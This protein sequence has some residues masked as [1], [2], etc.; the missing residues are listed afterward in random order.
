MLICNHLTFN[1]ER[2]KGMFVFM[3]EHGQRG[4]QMESLWASPFMAADA[5]SIKQKAEIPYPLKTNFGAQHL[6]NS[7]IPSFYLISA[8]FAGFAALAGIYTAFFICFFRFPDKRPILSDPAWVLTFYTASLFFIIAAQRVLSPQYMI[9]PVPVVTALLF[10]S[11]KVPRS[12]FFCVLLLYVFSWLNFDFGYEKLVQFD[13]AAVTILV[14]R[15]MFLLIVTGG[16][17]LRLYLS[18]REN[19]NWQ[20]KTSQH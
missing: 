3:S 11:N 2:E 14:I 15:N 18:L 8:K 19:G 1:T 13:P 16:L 6:D 9:W 17:F 10:A 4:I 12:L 7:V 20:K 5:A